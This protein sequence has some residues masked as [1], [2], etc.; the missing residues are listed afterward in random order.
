MNARKLLFYILGAVS[1]VAA[2]YFFIKYLDWKFVLPLALAVAGIVFFW[3][4][5]SPAQKK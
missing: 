5:S 1:L 4:G 3:L 2:A